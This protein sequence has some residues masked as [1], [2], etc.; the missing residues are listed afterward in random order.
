MRAPPRTHDQAANNRAKRA[1]VLAAERVIAAE[2]VDKE[3]SPHMKV[4]FYNSGGVTQ[5]VLDD[6][7]EHCRH[8]HAVMFPEAY[9]GSCW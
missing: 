6:V 3:R 1:H 8:L 5:Q 9:S 7:R 4:G 2:A